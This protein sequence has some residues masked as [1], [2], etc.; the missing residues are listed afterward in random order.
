MRTADSAPVLSRPIL[1]AGDLALSRGLMRMLLTRLGYVVTCVGTGGE[2]IGRVRQA[3]FA[4]VLTALQLP[5]LTGLD[6]ARRLRAITSPGST[7]PILL[8]GDSLDREGLAQAC[9]EAGIAIY[10]PKPISIS[11]LVA[12]VSD[13]T[14]H[15][16]TDHAG[17]AAMAANGALLDLAHLE[18]FTGGDRAL[19]DELVALYLATAA[20]YVERMRAAL[21]DRAAWA[22]GAHALKGASANFGAVA[23][24]ALAAKAELS[25]PHGGQ[26]ERIEQALDEVRTFFRDHRPG[27]PSMSQQATLV[28]A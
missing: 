9:R 25:Q 16:R 21:Q 20:S 2:A 14:R 6:L 3:S 27:S 17:A 11:R 24:A 15:S 5:D 19:E 7:P 26:L 28:G 22:G 12:A 18:S 13:L 23:V 10:L 8:F 4:A 1:I